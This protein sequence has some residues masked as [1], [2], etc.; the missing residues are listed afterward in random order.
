MGVGGVGGMLTDC[1]KMEGKAQPD[2]S[3]QLREAGHCNATRLP[4]LRAPLCGFLFSLKAKPEVLKGH[5]HLDISCG[6][7]GSYSVQVLVAAGEHYTHGVVAFAY[8]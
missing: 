2:I 1:A 5:P 4:H 7:H 3:A 8:L 6:P